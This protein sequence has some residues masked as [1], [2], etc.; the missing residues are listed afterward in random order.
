MGNKIVT[1]ADRK[2]T[3]APKTVEGYKIA[4]ENTG[5]RISLERG[6]A[7]RQQEEP[8]QARAQGRQLSGSGRR[9][10]AVPHYCRSRMPCTRPARRSAHSRRTGP[11][12]PGRGR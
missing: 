2:R 4:K 1:E 9:L 5:Q 3:P 7:T 11:W 12:P 6:K 8:R 10:P